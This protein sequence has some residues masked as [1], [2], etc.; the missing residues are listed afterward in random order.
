MFVQVLEVPEEDIPGGM[1]DI[2]RVGSVT[3]I[4]RYLQAHPETE[5]LSPFTQTHESVHTAQAIV[6]PFFRW[7]SLVT[8]KLVVD[9]FRE[10]ARR[11]PDLLA[12]DTMAFHPSF[13]YLDT[14]F[15]VSISSRSNSPSGPLQ[16]I[17][18]VGLDRERL[19]GAYL[20]SANVITLLENA[21]S[22]IQYKLTQGE[23]LPE[24]G[25]YMR[26]AKRNPASVEILKALSH[27]FGNDQV[28]L[29][30]F[31]ALVQAAFHT[32]QPVRTFI[33]LFLKLEMAMRSGSMAQYLAHKGPKR[34]VELFDSYL[35][36]MTFDP[37][38]LG[39][40]SY[41]KYFRLDPWI[42]SNLR[43]GGLGHPILGRATRQWG[44]R[45]RADIGCR[46]AL[47]TPNGYAHLFDRRDHIF[48]PPIRLIR[49]NLPTGA[50]VIVDGN[51]DFTGIADTQGLG[52]A[53]EPV[54]IRASLR[55]FLTIFGYVR[56]QSQAL[57]DSAY[58]LCGHFA[59]SHFQK[60]LCNSWV[61]IPRNFED[62]GFPR[63]IAELGAHF[64]EAADE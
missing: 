20:F 8:W 61:F 6:Y 26:W 24:W 36:E 50:V 33:D 28:L 40:V 60:N 56:G 48:N 12:A 19:P 47:T 5:F 54:D 1:I 49:F 41:K 2:V 3:G 10:L 45:E 58:R 53:L 25:L 34:W 55:D 13:Y 27:L 9:T 15:H 17:G 31:P 30:A 44:E 62:C 64:R 63:R 16:H 14:R 52:R 38:D 57:M 4:A 35:D 23:D 43:V 18:F 22:L 29:D 51:L 21:A 46:Y 39:D 7:Y 32:N 37:P 11:E 59:C 42:V